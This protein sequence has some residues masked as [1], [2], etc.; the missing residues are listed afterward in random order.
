M[1]VF[2]LHYHCKKPNFNKH[3][4]MVHDGNYHVVHRH[5]PRGGHVSRVT[6]AGSKIFIIL[7][8]SGEMR[9]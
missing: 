5:V 2:T 1:A 9:K 3:I 7:Q 8:S 6:S 4:V